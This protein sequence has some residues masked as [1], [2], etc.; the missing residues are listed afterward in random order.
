M[1]TM[2]VA[3]SGLVGENQN[4]RIWLS[5]EIIIGVALNGIAIAIL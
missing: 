2:G 4:K 3:Y 5:R 1:K